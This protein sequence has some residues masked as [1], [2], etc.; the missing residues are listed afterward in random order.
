LAQASGT[1]TERWEKAVTA[2]KKAVVG[3]VVIGGVL[4]LLVVG[5]MVRVSMEVSRV[6]AVPLA[7]HDLA[8][9]GDG[10]WR[11]TEMFIGSRFDVEVTVKDHRIDAISVIADD[12]RSYAK[13]ARAVLDRVVKAQALTVD[14]VTGA[15]NTSRVFLNAVNDALLKAAA[16]APKP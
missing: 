2:R 7:K 12:G 13:E 5:T 1:L 15:T 14:A 11:G 16:P 8:A 3:G 10:A 9:I 4:V 6:M